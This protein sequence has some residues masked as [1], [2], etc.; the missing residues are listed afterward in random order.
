MK[1]L[2]EIRSRRGKLLEKM[3]RLDQKRD[4]LMLK[5][6]QLYDECPHTNKYSTNAMGRDPGGAYC[7][8]CGKSW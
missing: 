2:E 3:T 4:R 5:I 6:R 1:T 8:D 7:P